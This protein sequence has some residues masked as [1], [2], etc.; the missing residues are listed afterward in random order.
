MKRGKKGGPIEAG[1]PY[2][3][4]EKGPELRVFERSGSIISNDKL[5]SY[6]P[7]SR[8]SSERGIVFNIEKIEV[9][10][11]TTTEQARNLWSELKRIAKENENEMRIS[12][13][14]API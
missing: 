3:V 7:V 1:K 12:L 4:G 13:G 5:S 8:S 14:L 9:T 10:G 2:I 11:G 6:Q